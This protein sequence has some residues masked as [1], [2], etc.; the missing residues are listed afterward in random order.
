VKRLVDLAIAAG[1]LVSAASHGYLYLRGYRYIPVVGAGFLVLASV[2]TALAIL[3]ALGGPV[4]LRFAALAGSVGALVVFA[5][6]RSVGLMGFTEHG[7]QPAPHAVVSVLAE[8]AIAG[9]SAW[10]LRATT[11]AHTRIRPD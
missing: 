6:S 5:L 10:S 2:F 11:S 7:W 9:L 4:W 8:V 1:M 3:I